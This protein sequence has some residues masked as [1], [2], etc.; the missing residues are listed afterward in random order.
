MSDP[1]SRR[2]GWWSAGAA[3]VVLAL[4]ILLP[5]GLAHGLSP[6]PDY[7]TYVQ[8]GGVWGRLPFGQDRI[9]WVTP[10]QVPVGAS[11][12]EPPVEVVAFRW[13]A[14]G[15]KMSLVAKSAGTGSYR[16]FAYGREAKT[17]TPVGVAVNER[18]KAYADGT[19]VEVDV[20]E[21]Q[22]PFGD[23]TARLMLNG[24]PSRM[25]VF[26]EYPGTPPVIVSAPE[27]RDR[28]CSHLSY[29]PSGSYLAYA[30]SRPKGGTDVWVS[31]PNGRY[32]GLIATEAV[33][34]AFVPPLRTAG[35]GTA[36]TGTPGGGSGSGGGFACPA[37]SWLFGLTILGAGAVAL[38]RG[39]VA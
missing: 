4:W 14:D 2:R 24:N 28:D 9:A 27:V 15:S 33:S 25:Q 31:T 20:T 35:G 37:L 34:P 26:I 13:A 39:G 32:S 11:G 29:S 3:I 19:P 22:A 6:L 36:T 1:G 17:V 12:L 16:E 7:V 10:D 8:D 5:A 21:A 38:S 23:A 30:V 18:P